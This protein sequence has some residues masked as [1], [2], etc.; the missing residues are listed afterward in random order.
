MKRV[1]ATD[2]LAESF[3][4]RFRRYAPDEV[5]L[6]IN[7]EVGLRIVSPHLFTSMLG[8]GTGVCLFDISDL[9]WVGRVQDDFQAKS[10]FKRLVLEQE[11]T[12]AER[13]GECHD[14]ISV[15]NRHEQDATRWP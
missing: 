6:Y 1:L 7:S 14:E 10:L 13:D 2:G 5:L 8:N 12:D 15:L 4:A 11:V 3:V 9:G